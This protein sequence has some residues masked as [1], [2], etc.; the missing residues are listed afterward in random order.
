MPENSS[1][2]RVWEKWVKETVLADILAEETP[3]PVP[4]IDESGTELE[5]TEEYDSY[6][7]G[8][9]SGDYLYILYLLDQP[10]KKAADVVPVYVG[11]TGN[12]ASRLLDHF[13]RL[14]DAL[15]ISE[16]EDEALLN[17]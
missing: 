2:K 13:R 3:D 15:P 16:W 5:M 14:R 10:A 8:R 1:K 6:R 12:T 11:E 7:L 9:G 17:H 4:M